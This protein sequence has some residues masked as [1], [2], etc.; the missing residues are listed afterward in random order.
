MDAR[1]MLVHGGPEEIRAQAQDA[2]SS[3]VLAVFW[4]SRSG[5]SMA[6]GKRGSPRRVLLG[7]LT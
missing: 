7:P 1:G 4:T 3:S 6:I 5:S 2:V